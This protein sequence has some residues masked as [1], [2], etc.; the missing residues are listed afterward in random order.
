MHEEGHVSFPGLHAT[1]THLKAI[2]VRYSAFMV[3]LYCS[4]GE[5]KPRPRDRFAAVVEAVLVALVIDPDRADA[6][7]GEAAV[8]VGPDVAIFD[9]ERRVWCREIE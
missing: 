4:E 7:V 6:A 3:R 2:A 1:R 9:D 5:L 8:P